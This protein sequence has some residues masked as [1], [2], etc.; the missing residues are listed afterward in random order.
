MAQRHQDHPQMRTPLITEA[1]MELRFKTQLSYGLVPG[2]LYEALKTT[3]P[4]TEDLPLAQFPVDTTPPF[5][6][7]HRLLSPDGSRLCQMGVGVVSVNHITYTS[8]RDFK[9]DCDKV[10][11]AITDIGLMSQT[12]RMG[13][14]YINTAVIDRK[15]TEMIQVSFKIPDIIGGTVRAQEHRWMSAFTDSGI[16]STTIAWPID[17]DGKS[18][19][20]ID[21]DNYQEGDQPFLTEKVLH[22][23]DAA[24]ENIYTVFTNILTPGYYRELRGEE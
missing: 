5:L 16:L 17:K 22:W 13:L 10:L 8:Y 23:L 19:L 24:H 4:K 20:A 18:G 12:N 2:R 11:S 6:V 3:F 9:D 1:I 7:R 21:L 14:R 15:W